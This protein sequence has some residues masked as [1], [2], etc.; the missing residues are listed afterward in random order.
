[1]IMA[2]CLGLSFSWC[3]LEVTMQCHLEALFTSSAISAEK[4]LGGPAHLLCSTA[5]DD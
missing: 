3:Y 5:R 2:L 1:M 4:R